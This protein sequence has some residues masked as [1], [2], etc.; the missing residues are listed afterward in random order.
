MRPI[1]VS[2]PKNRVRTLNI[3]IV[4]QKQVGLR[5]CLC[6]PTVASEQVCVPKWSKILMGGIDVP[7]RACE[8]VVLGD[9][10]SFDSVRFVSMGSRASITAETVRRVGGTIAGLAIGSNQTN[11]VI[12]LADILSVADGDGLGA[13]VEGLTLG[14]FSFD[15]YKSGRSPRRLP[16]ITLVV[17]RVLKSMSGD[18]KRATVVSEATNYA[19]T[20]AHEPANVINPV[21]LA[22][23]ARKLAKQVG[24]TCKV[25]DHV[26]MKR[27]KM[28]AMLAVGRASA[29]PPRL[30]VLEYAGRKKSK[31]LVLVGK[32]VTF[33]TGGYSIKD[34]NGIVGM[35]Y[36]K[37]GGTAVLGIMKAVAA[38]KPSGPVVG[39]I[40]AAENMIGGDAYRPND[41]VRSMSGKTIEIISTDAEGRMVLA[42]AMTYVQRF[43]KPRG[44]V[45]LATLTGGVVI[46]LG[47]VY[48]GMFCEDDDLRERLAASG[49][50]T[51]ERLW[52]LPMDDD[53]FELIRCDDCDFKNSGP[54]EAHASIGAVFLKQFV[55]SSIPWAHLDIAGVAITDKA[56][57]YCPRGG[58]GFGVR[59]M[60]DFLERM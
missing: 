60:C 32:A 35:K 37:C 40:A 12:D 39:V 45:D 46:A 25:I 29:T 4:S 15:R 1:G 36:D 48:G 47:R 19:R 7:E 51:N 43:Y 17:P 49:R 2:S 53:Y 18:V 10:G 11:V 22:A 34:K 6:V 8:H 57:E 27:L 28:G 59:L 20:I 55:D 14:S 26:G 52:S 23:E 13:L 30:I 44:I 41:I 50:R 38:L 56:T 58:N 42:D 9:R 3:K 21:T 5:G 54:R 16:R 33:D 31:P 24:L